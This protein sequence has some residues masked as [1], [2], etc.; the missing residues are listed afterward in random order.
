MEYLPLGKVAGDF[1]LIASFR[2]L[3][4]FVDAFEL[5]RLLKGNRFTG[6]LPASWSTMNDLVLM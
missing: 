1:S 4:S 5:L 2:L 3:L 6:T